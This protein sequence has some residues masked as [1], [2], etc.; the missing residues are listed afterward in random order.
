MHLAL[1]EDP[2]EDVGVGVGVHVC[3]RDG[4]DPV[5]FQAKR[6][7]GFGFALRLRSYLGD[8]F[9]GFDDVVRVENISVAVRVVAAVWDATG[10]VQIQVLDVRNAVVAEF[11]SADDR[12]AQL[13]C[14]LSQNVAVHAARV[15]RVE[16]RIDAALFR[17]QRHPVA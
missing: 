16:Y 5:E 8:F 2:R 3:I 10:G 15:G 6:N 4:V 14:H 9:Q 11:R 13:P 17:I 1:L 12:P 7:D